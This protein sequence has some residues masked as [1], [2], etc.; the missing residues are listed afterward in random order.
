MAIA[1]VNGAIESGD[2]MHAD[3][4]DSTIR[5]DDPSSYL[6]YLERHTVA[7]V[8][9]LARRP[10]YDKCKESIEV[11]LKSGGVGVVEFVVSQKTAELATMLREA[12]ALARGTP[13]TDELLGNVAMVYLRSLAH[14]FARQL[15]QI[16]HLAA[17]LYNDC[18]FLSTLLLQGLPTDG[19]TVRETGQVLEIRAVGTAIFQALLAKQL[20]DVKEYCVPKQFSARFG[21]IDGGFVD[22]IERSLTRATARVAQLIRVLSGILDPDLVSELAELLAS[23]VLDW[24]WTGM[25]SIDGLRQDVVARLAQVADQATVFVATIIPSAELQH[26]P[27]VSHSVRKLETLMRM[28]TMNLLQL[29]NAFRRNDFVDVLSLE[30]FRSIIVFLFPD[31]AMKR[32]F[33]AEIDAEL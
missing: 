21:Q 33:L 10:S 27:A 11:T 16:P 22:L 24:L 9:E 32:A 7:R 3:D 2:G 28:T 25:L 23:P 20:A 30:E 26:C 15:D 17:L 18:Q 4:R 14:V 6:R 12:A 31:T 13:A 8:L 1:V 5:P 19:H 29:S